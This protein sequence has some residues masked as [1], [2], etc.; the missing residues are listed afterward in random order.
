MG[1]SVTHHTT[2][3]KGARKR[4]LHSRWRDPRVVHKFASQVAV[5]DR[6]AYFILGR[7]MYFTGKFVDHDRTS[8]E[9]VE[10]MCQSFRRN[11][12]SDSVVCATVLL[13][14]P[15]AISGQ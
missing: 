10:D 13:K 14:A 7:Q 12:Q 9:D 2:S 4:R 6:K 5:I 1:S 3:K 11:V 15:K 8:E